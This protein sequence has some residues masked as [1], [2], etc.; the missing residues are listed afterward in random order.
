MSSSSCSPSPSTSRSS[1]R[2]RRRSCSPWASCATAEGYSV[3]RSGL[4][5]RRGKGG[6]ERRVSAGEPLGGRRLDDD[7]RMEGHPRI[8]LSQ[9]ALDPPDRRDLDPEPGLREIEGRHIAVEVRRAAAVL[10]DEKE[11]RRRLEVGE[12]VRRRRERLATREHDDLLELLLREP[13]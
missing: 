6:R 7:V 13:L 4:R 12:E 10:A 8:V 2:T 5:E 9:A 11:A 1:S 3:D